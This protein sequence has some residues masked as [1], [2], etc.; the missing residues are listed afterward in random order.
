MPGPLLIDPS[1]VDPT[2]IA[3]GIDDLRAA[4]PQRFEMEQLAGVLRFEPE[5]GLI[6]G[7]KHVRDDEF[8]VRGHIP[9]RPVLPGVLMVEAAAQ[10][11]TFYCRRVLPEVHGFW[12]F[13][14]IDR[15]KFRGVVRPGDSFVIAAKCTE[16]RP[17]RRA[18]FDCQGFVGSKLAFE[19]TVTGM[20]I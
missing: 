7:V 16:L 3:I 15:V 12:G 13:A 8:W 19:G 17:P 1:S 10:L 4:N 20:I 14:G 6:V 18:Q 11:C 5:S 9:G 2:A